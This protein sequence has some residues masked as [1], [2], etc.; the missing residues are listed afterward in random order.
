MTIFADIIR[1]VNMFIK[2]IFKDSNVL[3]G[4]L[5]TKFILF[6]HFYI[7]QGKK[8]ETR[9]VSPANRVFWRLNHKFSVSKITKN[10]SLIK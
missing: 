6:T 8:L 2:I 7:M 1:I 9:F 3:K 10:Y 4:S 5:V